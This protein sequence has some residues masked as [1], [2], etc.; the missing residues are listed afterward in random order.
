MNKPGSPSLVSGLARTL[1]LI[2]APS[3]RLADKWRNIALFI[4]A[5]RNPEAIE[6]WRRYFDPAYYLRSNPDIV[7]SG[8]DAGVHFL[9]AGGL[10]RRRPSADFDI[11]AYLD[12]YP[13][14]AEA[15][16]NPLLHYVLFGALENRRAPFAT[17]AAVAIETA[18]QPV[19]APPPSPLPAPL[20]E[21]RAVVVIHN[22]WPSARPLISVV[23][24]C[25]N[26]GRYV[27][28][29]VRSILNQTFRNLEIIVVEGGSTDPDSVAKVRELEATAPPGV[30]V[31][32]RSEPH[33][34]GDNRNYGIGFARG[35]Y[36][37][38]LDADDL[39]RPVYLEVA[40]F[41]AEAFGYD[42]VYPSLQGF[43]DSEMRWIINDASFPSIFDYNQVTTVA[44]YRRAV[45]AHA[46]GYRDWTLGKQH[47]PEDWDFWIR[48]LAHGCRPK[49][50]R[51]PLMLYRMH[52]SG[53]T[54]SSDR[55]LA[56][57]RLALR[58]ANQGLLAD[59]PRADTTEP[60]IT[61]P[62]ANLLPE[63]QDSRP[64]FLLALPY[65]TV[66]GAEKLFAGLVEYLIGRGYQPII[67][68]SLILSS[69]MP[70]NSAA[71]EQ[72]TPHLYHL[73]QLFHD[74]RHSRQFVKYLIRRYRVTTLMLAGCEF[75]YSLLPELKKEFPALGTVD[76]LFND[77]V[78]VHRNRE[79][80]LEIDATI[81][82]SPALSGTLA[83][84]F[85]ADLSRVHVI[86]HGVG[87]PDLPAATIQK[88][89][90]V[91]FFGRFSQ[92]KAPDLFVQIAQRLARRD[93]LSFIM[94]GDGPERAAVDALI[95]KYRL[96]GRLRN[97]GLV[98]DVRPYMHAA[99]IV[100]VPSR[101]DGMPLTVLEAQA[102]EKVVVASRV[103]SLPEMIA[104]GESGFLCDPGD[105][106]A[107]CACI[108]RLAGDPDLRRRIGQAARR[109]V[110][111][112]HGE[113]AMFA[114]YQQVF[115]QVTGAARLKSKEMGACLTS[116]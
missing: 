13:D 69:A 42:L 37:C 2:C 74:D 70:E 48:L 8:V 84:R 99:G 49:S 112:K 25:F 46:G 60:Q 16:V 21:R 90:T 28:E 3:S 39:L 71:F 113:A 88:V 75:T 14:V 29:A 53:L 66:G 101:L 20:P 77:T 83:R 57:Q 104:D 96:A 80:A 43:G 35:R 108:A 110:A 52:S 100:V 82:P 79:R 111:E 62:F 47:V 44:L 11:Q 106:D 32:Y 55:D 50:I 72:L 58:E 24:P 22:D 34:V 65:I 85:E 31:L 19:G 89:T 56:R 64:G 97:L 27:A 63:D 98:E 105:V 9:I 17:A 116:S 78:H 36:I 114:R 93:D 38:C 115:D 15:R 18:L 87:I 102:L 5:R 41:L 91:A 95:E 86:P 92:E 94:T 103:G 7:D 40:V 12:D 81:V 107:F 33:L 73:R 68:T 76:Q 6:R 10:E 23:I 61:G 54:A 59:A 67:T 1:L 109:S 30:R 4:K 26:Y 45:W 51:E